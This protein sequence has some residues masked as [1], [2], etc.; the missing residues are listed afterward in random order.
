M[1]KHEHTNTHT[2]MRKLEPD[3]KSAQATRGSNMYDLSH[4]KQ[5][6]ASHPQIPLAT[7]ASCEPLATSASFELLA[8]WASYEPLATWAS[9]EPLATWA[10]YEPLAKPVLL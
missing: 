10:S 6:Q 3:T 4:C 2:N 8:T 1:D 5:A 9:Y 7:W